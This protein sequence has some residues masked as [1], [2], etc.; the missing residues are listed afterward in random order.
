MSSNLATTADPPMGWCYSS[1][2]KHPMIIEHHLKTSIS[3]IQDYIHQKVS[4]GEASIDVITFVDFG[5]T[6]DF[7]ESLDGN[8]VSLVTL[9][10]QM[11]PGKTGMGIQGL[12]PCGQHSQEGTN[13][14]YGM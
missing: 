6:S 2:S 12:Q 8:R 1:G 3:P 10:R 4:D 11:T 5:T 13:S 9:E 14:S 7:Q